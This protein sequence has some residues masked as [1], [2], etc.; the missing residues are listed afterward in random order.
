MEW[1]LDFET[2]AKRKIRKTTKLLLAKKELW[3]NLTLTAARQAW[4]KSI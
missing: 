2:K 1:I 4:P 3:L